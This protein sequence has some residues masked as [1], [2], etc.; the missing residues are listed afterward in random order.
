MTLTV[1]TL[2]QAIK[3][4]HSALSFT[5]VS[6][7]G[8]IP[9]RTLGVANIG[10][11]VMNFTVSTQTL[12][13]GQQWLSATPLSGS[14][15]AGAPA[16]TV[17]VTASPAGLAPGFYYG[18][19]R[20]DSPGAANTPHVATIALRVLPAGQDPGPSI[21]PSEI[22]FTATEGAP[23]PGSKVLS[24]YNISGTP[25]TYVS[26]ITASDTYNTFGI[27]PGDATLTLTQPT[28]LVV[29]PLTSGL[30]AGVY[31]AV[32]DLQFSD[33][34]VREVGIRTVVT[35][36]PSSSA[37]ASLSKRAA[38]DTTVT[39]CT[40]SAVGSGDHDPGPILLAYRRRGRSLSNRTSSTIAAMR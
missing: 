17:S 24:V 14:V 12:S 8:V 3:L 13:G 39:G 20:V 34:N 16:Q 2:D 40:P 21:E 38:R 26:S 1:S 36:A 33:G 37:Q 6:G 4:S 25:Q 9:P 23:P 7:G 27:R 28:R 22:V 29:Q 11:G 10:R 30:S 18:L 15:A 5:A 19:V 31:D 32:L 35:A